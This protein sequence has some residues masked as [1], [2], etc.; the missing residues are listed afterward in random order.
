MIQSGSVDYNPPHVYATLAAPFDSH[1]IVVL[2]PHSHG[3]ACCQRSNAKRLGGS[4]AYMHNTFSR[5][6]LYKKGSNSGAP[7]NSNFHPPSNF[8]RF[9]PLHPDL[10][11][12]R[13]F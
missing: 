8:R 3:D 12:A 5:E 2:E 7:E 9:E 10:Q 4:Y 6:S 11:A 1:M 13:E